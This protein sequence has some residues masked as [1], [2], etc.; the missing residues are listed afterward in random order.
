VGLFAASEES[1]LL[2]H[3]Y[4]FEP[5]Y[6]LESIEKHAALMWKEKHLPAGPKARVDDQGREF[7]EIGS[8]R[9]GILEELEKAHVYV[10][11]LHRRLGENEE[12][13]AGLRAQM[14]RLTELVQRFD[15]DRRKLESVVQQRPDR[16]RWKA[17]ECFRLN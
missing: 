4:I 17:E 2:H 6:N 15:F 10:E 8:Q 7:S 3:C 13:I 11:Q 1:E 5:E 14:N 12:Q 9:R 16:F